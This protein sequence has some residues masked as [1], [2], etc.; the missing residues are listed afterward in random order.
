MAKVFVNKTDQRVE[1]EAKAVCTHCGFSKKTITAERIFYWNADEPSDGYFDYS[2]W[3]K[4]P[5]CGHSL[6][7]FNKRHL[8][9]LERFVKAEMRENPNDGNGY[10]NS[11]LA[12]RLP[13]W[14]KAGK[15]RGRLL[16]SITKLNALAVL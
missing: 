7:A 1:S 2:L 14:I 16:E 9:F 12:S 15:N 11:S 13:T 4:M 3:L 5:S 8:D 10:A 6:W